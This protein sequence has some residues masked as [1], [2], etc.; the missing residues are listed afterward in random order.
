MKQRVEKQIGNEILWFETGEL[1]KQA[2]GAC[3]C[4]YGDSS[5]IATVT[6]AA[7]NRFGSVIRDLIWTSPIPRNH[8][9][10]KPLTL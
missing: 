4:G 6:I 8:A 5:V 1:A 7:S 9:C 10:C 3:L 2:A